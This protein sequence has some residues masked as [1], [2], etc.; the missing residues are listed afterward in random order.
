LTRSLRQ[1]VLAGSGANAF[2]QAI[3][4][5]IQ[6]FSLPFFLHYWNASTY[7]AW[8]ILSAIPSYLSMAD[9]GMVTTAGN[10]M[11]IA[12]G[13]RD[14]MQANRVFQSAL[15]F[16]LIVC[17]LIS[18]LAIPA[19]L[20]IPLPGITATSDERIA[21][22]ILSTG[23]LVALFGGL[24]DTIFKATGRYPLGTLLGNLV[25]LAEWGGA[26]LGLV[27]VGSFSAVAIG[28]L[29]ARTLGLILVTTAAASGKHEIHWSMRDA[30]MEEVRA[31]IKPAF[32]FMLFP[33][34]SALSFQGI[35]LLVGQTLGPSSVA[36]FN[37][38]RTL[39]RVEVQATSIFS[40]ALWPEFS[41][42]YGEGGTAAVLPLYRRAVWLGIAL[43]LLLSLALYIV[44]PLLLKLWTNG[45]IGFEP[46]FMVV[47]LVYAAVGSSAH[48]PRIFLLATNKHSRLA[49]WF[50]VLAIASLG[51]AAGI[52]RNWGTVGFG[53]AM[54][55]SEFGVL[56]VCFH[57]TRR[58]MF[59]SSM[60]V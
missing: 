14:H 8:L 12:M 54:L 43:S 22:A 58:L 1:R 4:I 60:P 27:L 34:A 44:A 52:G 30:K 48:V 47:M 33:L 9:V 45:A 32:S 21:V 50:L 10:K 36:V 18:V 29:L 7:G 53:M 40:H 42:L 41:R 13:Q 6:L 23:V 2:G 46:L 51:L 49:L 17:G 35:T 20:W 11:T 57:L 15:L 19:A 31:M 55:I 16:M 3:T 38:Y 39:A 24:A 28:G 26:M 56:W 59:S 37:T 25:R 5:G